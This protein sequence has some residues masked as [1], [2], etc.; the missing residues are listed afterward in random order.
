MG[1]AK[2]LLLLYA[3][4]YICGSLMLFYMGV[5]IVPGRHETFLWFAVPATLVSLKLS[6]D[7]VFYKG[8]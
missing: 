2:L 7:G 5:D 1:A 8:D 4:T 3:Q 6:I